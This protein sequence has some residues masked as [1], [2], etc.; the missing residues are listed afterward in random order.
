MVG[1]IIEIE[2]VP[3]DPKGVNVVMRTEQDQPTPVEEAL[4]NR[5]KPTLRALPS[6]LSD[7]SAGE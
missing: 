1:F 7:S 3:G 4:A 5:F 6:S 2:Q